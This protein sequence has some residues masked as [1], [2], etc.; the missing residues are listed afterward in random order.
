MQT[1]WKLRYAVMLALCANPAFADDNTNDRIAQLQKMVEAQQVQMKAMADEL[2]ALQRQRPLAVAGQESLS[3][4][5]RNQLQEQQWQMQ[6]M[7]EEL[8]ALQQKPA[9]VINEK[10]GIGLKTSNGDFSI[11]LHGLVQG[12]YREVDPGGS[13]SASGGW[14]IRKARPWIEGILFGWIDYRLTPEFA[15]TTSNVATPPKRY[16]L[17]HDE[18][19]GGL[20]DIGNT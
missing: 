8:K 14:I 9:V 2:K 5:S 13:T 1:N 10:D 19:Q 17:Q 11:K 15:T 4:E 16:F 12:D 3:D 18:L 7:S 20:Y 6:A